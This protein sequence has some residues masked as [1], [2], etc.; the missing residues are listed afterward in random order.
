MP[1][2]AVVQEHMVETHPLLTA[3]C[4][5]KVFTGDDELAD[6]IDKQYVIDI[7][8][9]FPKD[10]AAALK[11][12]IGKSLWQAVH[13]PTIVGRTCDGGTIVQ[14]VCHADRHVVHRAYKLCAGE[15]A[16]ADLAFAAK[17][18]SVVEM[19]NLLPARRA[20]GPNEPGGIP[21]ASWRT[22]S[23]PTAS[24]RTTRAS[25]LSK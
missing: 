21:S 18:A 3:D 17:H 19:G 22:W 16:V 6:S 8:K 10:Q 23:S 25:L 13:I 24:T 7:N 1:G 20:R 14:M 2:A 5:V 11:K 15:A 12:A 9:A 4:F